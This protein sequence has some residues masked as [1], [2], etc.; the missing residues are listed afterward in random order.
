MPHVRSVGVGVWVETGSRHEVEGRGGMSH[1]IEHLVFKG[2]ATRSEEAIAREMDSVGGQMDALTTKEHTCSYV[3]ALDHH[4][5]LAVDLRHD[6]LLGS[7]LDPAE[8]ER[9]EAEE[10]TETKMGQDTTDD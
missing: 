4:L 7:L 5:P 9:E 6:I 2:T 3:Q 8:L 10:R 1:L